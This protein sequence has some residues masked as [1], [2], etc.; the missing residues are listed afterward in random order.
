M[1]QKRAT[2]SIK[3]RRV[4]GQ[5]R[6]WREQFEMPSGDVARAMG[7]SQARFSR[8]ERGY[9]RVSR[10]EVHDICAKIGVDDPEGVEEVSRIAEESPGTGWWASYSDRIGQ[11]YLD[12]IELESEAETIR[13]H[14]PVV[15]PGPIQTA[16]YA[17]EILTHTATRE[18][19]QGEMLVSIRMAR[20]EILTRKKPVQFHALVPE[21]ALHARFGEGP[22]IMPDQLRK[23]LDVADMPNVKLQIVPITAHPAYVT[24][25]P[26]TL[27]TFRHP[28]VPVASVDNQ[29]G[30]SHT[31]GAEEIKFLNAE[32]D[33]VGSI[34][35]SV[36]E[37]RDLLTEYLEGMRK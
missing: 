21:I 11:N 23:L 36:D 12:F 6:R 25:G 33:A 26:M 37:S 32:F 29:M 3:R 1:T 22:G 31:E 13:I 27:L 18:E 10:D 35:L 8:I 24:K 28:W 19:G 14:H 20:Q 9:Y 5:L 30:G 2:P 17:R 7:W 4:G 16:G 15:I 34:A